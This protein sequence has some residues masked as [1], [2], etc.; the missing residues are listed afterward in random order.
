MNIN[1]ELLSFIAASPT[2]YHA[3]ANIKAQLE[4]AGY[5]ALNEGDEWC[6][7]APGKYYVTRNGSSIIALRIPKADFRGFMIMASHSD[8]PTYRI[9]DKP[10]TRPPVCTPSSPWRVTAG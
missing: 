2:A 6:I 4:D 1:S 5:T 9:K 10:V 8:S 3:V 7:T